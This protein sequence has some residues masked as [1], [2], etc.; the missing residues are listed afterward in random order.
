MYPLQDTIGTN[1]EIGRNAMEVRPLLMNKGEPGRRCLGDV[2]F[3]FRVGNSALHLF[4][5][6]LDPV[7]VIETRAWVGNDRERCCLAT[8]RVS[9]TITRRLEDRHNLQAATSKR[10]VVRNQLL[11][12]Q[13]AHGAGTIAEERE[14]EGPSAKAGEA[15]RFTMNIL[16][17]EYGRRAP[18]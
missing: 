1:H 18:A 11:H 7:Q 10:L 3:R 2:P 12:P 5:R 13:I 14:Q 6:V 16:Y 8:D 15:D 17:L 4:R 9:H